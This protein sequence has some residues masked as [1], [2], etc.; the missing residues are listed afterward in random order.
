M[1]P[2]MATDQMFVSP[3][4][5]AVG[6]L[7]NQTAKTNHP[8]HPNAIFDGEVDKGRMIDPLNCGD[9]PNHRSVAEKK[10]LH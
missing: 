4:V 2:G 9:F 3:M 10:T 6:S 8:S 1:Q 7:T 5:S